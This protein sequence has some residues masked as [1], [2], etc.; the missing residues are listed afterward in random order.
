M[1]KA[2][3]FFAGTIN[4]FIICLTVL[5]CSY[6]NNLPDHYYV[7]K[8]GN[9]KLSCAFNV[10]A[11]GNGNENVIQSSKSDVLSINQ[12]AKL[13]LLGIIPLKD[14]TIEEVDRPVLIAGGNPFGIKLLT[15]GVMV[16]GIGSID[17]TNGTVTP[18]AAA[19]IKKGD[20]VISVNG[21]KVTSNNDIGKIISAS[22]GNEISVELKRGTQDMVVSLK[23]AYSSD[24]CCYKAGIWVRDSTAGIGTVT[25]YDPRTSVFGG[26]GHPVCDVDTGEI[27][28]ISKGEAVGVN[29]ND[30]HRGESGTPGELVGSFSTIFPIG[31][32]ET[33]N[34]T[35]IYGFLNEPPNHSIPVPMALRQE[36]EPG[37]AYIYTTIDGSEPK[38]YKIQI[39]K[40]DLNDNKTTKN[41]IIKVTDPELLAKTGGIVQGMSGSPII[42]NG[43]LV[44]AVT[45]VFVND[46]TRG[47]GI[48]CDTMYQF[49]SD[50]IR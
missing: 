41:M 43:K 35:G 45:H 4:A 21:K 46:P 48:F 13:K 9:L 8:G 42:Q 31:S 26:L 12:S 50:L 27:V 20:I 7:T 18:A 28:P 10:E 2:V 19:G 37:E 11:V 44:G 17:G 3:K 39:E 5:M 49:A 24:D 40:I 33:N 34:E 30:V 29:I 14:V 25:F 16:V 15:D 6:T 22:N 38:P 32:L 1:K 47:Y 23:P 36:V